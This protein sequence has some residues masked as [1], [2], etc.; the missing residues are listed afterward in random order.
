MK[1]QRN[2]LIAFLLNLSFSIFE[3]I[4]SIW[5]GSVAIAS[6]AIHDFGDAISIGIAWWLE[7]KSQQPPNEK[8]TYGYA[9]LSVIGGLITTTILCI[10]SMVVIFNAIQRLHNPTPVKYTGMI[11]FAIVGVIVNGIAT[12]T[13]HGGV[14]IN[15]KAVSLHMF[16]DVLGWV[17]VLVGAIIMRF[18]NWVS[19]DAIL[20]ILTS[21]LILYYAFCNLKSV[22]SIFGEV[23]PDA[24]DIHT[25]I[26]QLSNIENVQDVH[27]VHVWSLDGYKHYATLHVVADTQINDVKSEV[28]EKLSEYGI[29]HVTVEIESSTEQC[30]TKQCPCSHTHKQ[31]HIHC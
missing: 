22:F 15:Q 17:I 8:Y 25:L 27:H 9:R 13:T 12:Y 18:T 14:S 31:T 11:I 24:I 28:R 5:T 21:C 23:T 6:D 26:Q 4:G 30:H 10:S 2:I 3:L 20:S 7:R 19:L 29:T 1:S 16:E